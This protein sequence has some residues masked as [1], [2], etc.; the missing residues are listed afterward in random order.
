V[1]TGTGTLHYQ[2]Y[3]NGTTNSNIGGSP[4][5]S[6]QASYTPQTTTAGTT[7]YYVVVTGDCGTAKSN[8]VA[9][10]VN[11][12]TIC[13]DYTGDVF[14]NTNST[15]SGGIATV[16]L[17]FTITGDPTAT[18]NNVSALTAAD[19]TITKSAADPNN[20]GV[21]IGSISYSGGIVSAVCTVTLPSSAYSANV[22]FTLGLTNTNYILGSCT[23]RALVTVSTKVDGFVT[24]GGYL[25][26]DNTC[27]IKGVSGNT[28]YKDNYGFNI[29]YNKAGTNLQGNWNSIFRR[30]EN[31][32]VHTYQVKSS[33]AYKLDVYQYS[34]SSYRAEFTF[35][36]GN[37]KDLT[38]NNSTVAS[39][40]IIKVIVWD[41]GEPG[42]GIDKMYYE[43]RNDNTLLYQ[44]D[45][46]G[47]V[48]LIAKGNIQIHV[49]GKPAAITQRDV[50]NSSTTLAQTFELKASPNPTRSY[51]T[52]QL[53]NINSGAVN[54]RVTDI[55]GR[56][57]E[58]KQNLVPGQ[59]LR[60][61]SSYRPGIYIVEVRQGNTIK[62][63]KLVK[64]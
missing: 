42:S 50:Q 56:V 31:G 46:G 14:V 62:Q 57:V 21:V 61:G 34:A 5:G 47:A 41:N 30:M 15:S 48:Q 2:W 3:N 8:A 22:E 38:T 18:C 1:A 10:V 19:F 17:A 55:L 23:E 11:K 45:C 35:T 52:L 59:T 16:N 36:G 58:S 29:K 60:I 4:V 40:L 54:L 20:T 27:G 25:L 6:D 53:S 28:G 26:Q 9:V 51:S 44:T 43:V 63:I 24:G 49:P 33:Q 32:V 37:L 13:G 39:N 7:Y 64:Q 12:N